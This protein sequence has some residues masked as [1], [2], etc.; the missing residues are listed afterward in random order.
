VTAPSTYLRELRDAQATRRLELAKL[1]R[2]TPDA[3]N[4][5]L[6]KA[7]SVSRNTIAEDRKA[8]ME[9][10]KK[11]T[12][13]ETAFYRLKLL[14]KLEALLEVL[15][16]RRADKG[17][18]SLQSVDRE[19]TLIKEIKDLMGVRKP[20]VEKFDM[21]RQPIQFNTV[22]VSTDG[23]RSEPK[24]FELLQEPHALGAGHEQH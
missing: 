6:A 3:T 4:L 23:K 5:E 15:E 16:T 10:I 21:K 9:E 20:V 2:E 19:I 17:K 11:N 12:L 22:I 14:N 18:F 13:D 24:T 8:I 7:L 1:L